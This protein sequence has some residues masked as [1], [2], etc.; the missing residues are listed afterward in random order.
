M[1][2]RFC[3]YGFLKNQTYFGPFLI[4]VFLEKG[5]T[6]FEIGLLIACRELTV[7]LFE[8]LSG[9]VADVYGRRRSMIFSFVAYIASF[10]IFGFC[11]Q[12]AWL[13]VAMFFYGIGVAFRT[14]T[15][16]AIIFAWLR[17]QNRIDERTKVYGQTRSWSKIGSAVAALLAAGFVL[18][19]ENYTTIFFFSVIPYLI[20][21]INFIGYPKELDGGASSDFSLGRLFGH[22]KSSVIN[23]LGRRELRRLIFESMGFEGLFRAAKDYLQ[24]VLKSTALQAGAGLA[25]VAGLSEHKKAA[26]LIGPVYFCIFMLSA[27]ASR[28]SHRIAK[29][30]GEENRAARWLWGAFLLGF[31]ALLPA[32]LFEING[33]I[34]AGF[35]LLFILQNIWRP[36]LIS[37]F[38]SYGD[39]RQ[40]ATLLSIESQAK[41]LATM[42]IAP[43]LGWLVDLVTT[44]D[45]GG[46]FWP[47]GALG[48]IVAL[49]FFSLPKPRAPYND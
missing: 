8:I 44:N 29:R 30:A 2:F 18:L 46:E 36:I 42:L 25:I 11:E 13:F 14:G 48:I 27:L 7:N 12:L 16:K 6:F 49:F 28:W 4:L 9:A 37:R 22:L 45:L 5:L 23:A 26:L 47:V 24:P 35:I 34:I 1:L 40:G 17:L 15:H 20:G 31:S 21:I 38:D 39:E 32:M 19:S 3:L 33:L 43:L 41:S 10:L